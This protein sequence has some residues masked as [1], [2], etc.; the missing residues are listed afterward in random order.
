MGQDVPLNLTSGLRVYNEG[1]AWS[2]DGS[3][4]AF[5][6]REESDAAIYVVQADGSELTQLTDGSGYDLNPAWSPD[7]TRIAFSSRRA[8]D[9]SRIYTMAPD[10]SQIQPLTASLEGGRHSTPSW[11]PD[12]SQLAFAAVTSNGTDIFV[13]DLESGQLRQITTHSGI[14]DQPFWSPDGTLGFVSNRE[15]GRGDLFRMLP[16]D[17]P[18]NLTNHPARDVL[19]FY[20]SAGTNPWSPDGRWILFSSDRDSAIDS[21]DVYMLSVDDGTVRRL[22]FS[23]LTEF[24]FSWAPDSRRIAYDYSSQ[25]RDDLFV[26]DIESGRVTRVTDESDGGKRPVWSPD[27]TQLAYFCPALSAATF[28]PCP[29]QDQSRRPSRHPAC[30]HSTVT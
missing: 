4:I 19:W 18:E 9:E 1:A 14:D 8:G 23:R 12:G 16:S 28:A 2:P 11:S 3:Q 29:P 25:G 27:G 21:G 22:T 20:T 7:G 24:R 6:S 5:M 26:L 30:R 17:E 10:G 13:V 15:G